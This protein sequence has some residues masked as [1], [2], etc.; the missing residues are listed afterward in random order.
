LIPNPGAPPLTCT[1]HLSSA[2][3]SLPVPFTDIPSRSSWSTTRSR[4]DS[5]G[6]WRNR[7]DTLS[8][9]RFPCLPLSCP[10]CIP[11]LPLAV[12]VSLVDLSADVFR[13][14]LPLRTFQAPAV[15]PLSSV[16]LTAAFPLSTCFLLLPLPLQSKMYHLLH[17]LGLPPSRPFLT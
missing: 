6:R 8:I 14:D 3:L 4:F 15:L 12:T 9:S 7:S 13:R 16:S 5:W 1:L 10:L 17:A 11:A 2:Q